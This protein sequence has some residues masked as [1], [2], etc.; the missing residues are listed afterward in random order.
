MATHEHRWR[1]LT[2]LISILLLFIVS[3]FV[4]TLQHGILILNVLGATVLLAASYALSER[5]HLFVVAIVLSAI[6]IIGTMLLLIFEQH[7][8]ALVSDTCLILLVA[9]F[10]VTIL[11]YVLRGGRVTADKIFAAIC[12]YMLMDTPGRLVMRFLMKWRRARSPIYPRR[13]HTTMSRGWR[14]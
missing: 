2:L 5:K 4:A 14:D 8:A 13:A 3:P 12:V 6:S 10:S 7:W 1:H 11:G 9:F